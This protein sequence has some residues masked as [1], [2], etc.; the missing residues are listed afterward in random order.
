MSTFRSVFVLVIGAALSAGASAQIY[1]NGPLGTGATSERGD[2]APAGTAWSELQHDD[3]NTTEAN[4]IAGTS[5]YAPT[6]RLADDF[7]VPAGQNWTISAIET[8]A[9]QS[10]SAATPSPF[11]SATLQIWNGRP[12]DAG[13]FVLC[14]DSTA[15]RLQTSTDALKFRIFAS[16]VPPPGVKPGTTRKIWRNRYPVPAGCA[17]TNFF[18]PG[19]YW[20][21]FNSTVSSGTIH[22]YPLVTARGSRTPSGTLNARQSVDGV[23]SDIIDVGNPATAPDVQ[24]ELPFLLYGSLDT[25][26]ENGF[27]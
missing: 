8:F 6:F 15:N 2:V 12:G 11:V 24:V 17:G 10:G 3:G 16:A 13:A 23:W 1:S 19:A 26:F 25:I 4:A 22:F 5:G 20:L 9:Y 7:V 18:A 21:D 27:E 14:G